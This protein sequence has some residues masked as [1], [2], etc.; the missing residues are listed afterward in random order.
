MWSCFTSDDPQG[1]KRAGH[2][3]AGATECS[4]SFSQTTNAALRFLRAPSW[5][6]KYA[7]NM[8]WRSGGAG[9]N[10]SDSS[11]SEGYNS[12]TM[13]AGRVTLLSLMT[14]WTPPCPKDRFVHNTS[15]DFL[16]LLCTSYYLLRSRSEWDFL[17]VLCPDFA[18][19]S[20]KQMLY[21]TGV[22]TEKESPEAL[23]STHLR[24]TY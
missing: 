8:K 10:C 18:A 22:R 21:R 9:S 17:L 1:A 2:R 7:L 3:L 6:F 13:T 24:N 20:N 15:K 23:V 19:R 5:Y 14:W 11:R 4:W 16:I 12:G